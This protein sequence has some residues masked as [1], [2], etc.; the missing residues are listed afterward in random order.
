MIK[1]VE[2]D[3]KDMEKKYRK[4]IINLLYKKMHS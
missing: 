1:A 2:Q 3:T 4:P